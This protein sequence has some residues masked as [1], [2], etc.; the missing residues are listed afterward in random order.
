MLITSYTPNVSRERATAMF[1]SS[2]R[3]LRYGRLRIVI[4]FHLPYYLFLVRMVNSRKSVDSLYGIDA[5]TGRLDP[6]QFE[7]PVKAE[8]CREIETSYSLPPRIDSQAAFDR[9]AERMMRL[10]FM[11]G[12]FKLRGWKVSGDLVES[13]YLP[14]W[15][16][17]YERRERAHLEVIDALRGRFEGAKVREMVV[18][19]FTSR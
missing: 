13:F 4:D 6:Y 18:S 5:I 2:L 7:N 16:G 9:L 3:E 17:V 11:R 15:V 10:V 8:D 19:W 12:A 14:Y 1:L